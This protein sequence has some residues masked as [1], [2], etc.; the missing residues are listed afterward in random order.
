MRGSKG[1]MSTSEWYE[2]FIIEKTKNERILKNLKRL[3]LSDIPEHELYHKS[4]ERQAPN[5]IE[6]SLA[7]ANTFE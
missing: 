2:K 5:D 4:T 6:D 1:T 7:R 3:G